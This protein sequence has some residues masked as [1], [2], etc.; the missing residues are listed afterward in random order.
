[1]TAHTTWVY[2]VVVLLVYTCL[3]WNGF[4]IQPTLTP[5]EC[6]VP[7]VNFAVSHARK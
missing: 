4:L 1:M 2:P 6:V 3:T 5:D 7:N